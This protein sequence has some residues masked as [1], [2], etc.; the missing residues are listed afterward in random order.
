MLCFAD[1]T[2]EALAGMLR[3]G[4][5]GSNTV[6][7][8]VMVLDD[9]LAQLP[10]QIA[11]GHR[12]GDDSSL[13]C[14]TIV[15]R[16]DSAGCTEAFAA[17]CRASNVGFS[18]LCRS[19]LQI[20]SAIFDTLGFEELCHQAIKQNSED[21]KGA[22]VIELTELVDLSGWPEGTGLIVRREPLHR[23]VQHSLFWSLEYR[24]WGFCTDQDGD[25]V[26]LD[27][28][29]WAHAHVEQNIS[30]QK[31][32]GLLSFPFT[33]IEANRNWMATVLMAADLLRWFQL[34]CLDGYWA[35]ARPKA[36]RWGFLHAPGRLV[37][38]ARRQ[39]AC[40]LDGWPSAEA[41]IGAY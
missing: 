37:N 40:I 38:S 34:L 22:A 10:A 11:V 4:N 27:R 8:H 33:D 5:A 28:I 19:N 41:I 26:K 21:R 1:C 31:D 3:F 23:G 39:I 24:Y 30:C 2:G 20:H 18:V 9:A 16:A 17:A 36:L 29:M 12:V 13:V 7:D 6:A 32:L 25:A 35:K 15:M 14:R